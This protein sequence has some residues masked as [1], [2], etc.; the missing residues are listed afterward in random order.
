METNY[1][2]ELINIINLTLSAPDDTIPLN[3]K[4]KQELDINLYLLLIELNGKEHKGEI[5]KKEALI[6]DN[7]LRLLNNY[8]VQIELKRTP[9]HLEEQV[10]KIKELYYNNTAILN[11]YLA[12]SITL[13]N[14]L[15][16]GSKNDI[17]ELIID[18]TI[19]RSNRQKYISSIDSKRQKILELI[20][21]EEKI[22]VKEGYVIIDN[23]MLTIEE[24]K[25]IFS[26]LLNIDNFES[27]YNNSKLKNAQ[28]IVYMD[29][30][31]N[32][33]NKTISSK[34]ISKVLIQL[35]LQELNKLEICIDENLDGSNFIIE[36]MQLR[37]LPKQEI[38]N[39]KSPKVIIY[40]KLI[41]LSNE[42]IINKIL[43][44]FKEGNYYFVEDMFV[45]GKE[46]KDVKTKI[47]IS[48]II[49]YL[50]HILAST[51]QNKKKHNYSK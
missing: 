1:Q 19:K 9:E 31:S 40:N 20:K 33:T 29:I 15:S 49:S 38:I 50:T 36:N 34:R 46:E 32:I 21:K 13:E 18:I 22:S 6:I 26:Y 25:E 48:K 10:E 2:K 47:P 43:S 39:E 28:L 3:T 30:I 23:I 27:K 17:D 41:H 12:S 35:L 11:N 5:D 8:K 16:T 37:D 51:M 44:L 14:V 7:F 24:F 4:I 45:I 42:Y